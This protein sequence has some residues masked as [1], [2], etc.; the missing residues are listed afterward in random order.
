[1]YSNMYVLADGVIFDELNPILTGHGRNPP[2][3]ELHVTSAGRNRVRIGPSAAFDHRTGQH[4]GRYPEKEP[5]FLL[6]S[7]HAQYQTLL[8]P[9]TLG[10]LT[11]MIYSFLNFPLELLAWIFKSYSMTPKNQGSQVKQEA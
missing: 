3:Y 4:K 10:S 7:L 9:S 8:I 5:L 1:M 6:I 2:I 11:R